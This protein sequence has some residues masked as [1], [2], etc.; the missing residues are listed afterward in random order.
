MNHRRKLQKLKIHLRTAEL[1]MHPFKHL[2]ELK[3]INY[4]VHCVL[5]VTHD[6]ELSEKKNPLQLW[7]ISA[8][9][10]TNKI[11]NEILRSSSVVCSFSLAHSFWLGH[12]FDEKMGRHSHFFFR[13]F[14]YAFGRFI[15]FIFFGLM[16]G[17]TLKNIKPKMN[18]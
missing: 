4:N 16:F 9:K 14:S 6:I 13:C 1:R 7:R 5:M 18:F 12:C 2:N 10:Q 11:W 17:Q 8:N 15:L 3:C